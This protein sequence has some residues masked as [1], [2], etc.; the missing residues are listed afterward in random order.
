MMR[1]IWASEKPWDL[2]RERIESGS[3]EVSRRIR[4]E[5]FEAVSGEKPKVLRR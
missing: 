5:S 2:K 3:W 1:R 4:V